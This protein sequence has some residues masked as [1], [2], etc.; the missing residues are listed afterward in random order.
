M[1]KHMIMLKDATVHEIIAFLEQADQHGS[2]IPT[3]QPNGGGNEWAKQ[4][5]AVS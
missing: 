4:T 3:D 2:D 5:A 1:A